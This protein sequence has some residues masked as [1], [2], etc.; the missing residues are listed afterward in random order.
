MTSVPIGISAIVAIS[1]HSSRIWDIVE[2]LP[3]VWS[4]ISMLLAVVSLVF[5]SVSFYRRD[6]GMGIFALL[7]GLSVFFSLWI[8]PSANVH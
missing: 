8:M 7:G 5:C 6:F 4:P 3:W 1:R 2:S